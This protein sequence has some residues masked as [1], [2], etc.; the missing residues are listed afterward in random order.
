MKPH[1]FAPGAIERHRRPTQLVRLPRLPG[2]SDQRRSL[3]RWALA[4][5]AFLSTVAICSFAAGLIAGAIK[6]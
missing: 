4:V 3:M 1:P 6:P 2:T 5:L